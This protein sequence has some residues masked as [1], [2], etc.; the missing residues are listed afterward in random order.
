MSQRKKVNINIK[1]IGDQVACAKT[2]KLCIKCSDRNKCENMNVYYYP[3]EGM[4]TL[5]DARVYKR[6]NRRVRQVK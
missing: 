4:Q 6:V 3:D 1:F 5:S 2:P